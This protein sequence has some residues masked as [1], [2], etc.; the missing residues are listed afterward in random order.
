MASEDEGNELVADGPEEE[1][2]TMFIE[3]SGL[4][5]SH[6]DMRLQCRREA[7]C[8]PVTGDISGNPEGY[9]NPQVVPVFRQLE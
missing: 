4:Y 1:V 3:N 8:D 9:A 5:I 2:T 7:N 6:Y